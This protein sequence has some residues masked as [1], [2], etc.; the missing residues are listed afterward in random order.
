VG[1][2][3]YARALREVHRPQAAPGW[4][5]GGYRC[6]VTA[7]AQPPPDTPGA[8]F[9]DASPARIRAALT[10]G[11]AVEFDRQWQQVMARATRELDLTEV[12]DTLA[13]WRRVAW[14]TSTVG[15]D[16]YEAIL[17]SARHRASTGERHPGAVSW[18]QLRERLD[19]PG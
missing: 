7:A 8:P 16:Q 10:A 13:L 1:V 17:A 12:L 6:V 11:D 2:W 4:L 3:Q 15:P 9:A 5:S 19:L 18:D 14:A